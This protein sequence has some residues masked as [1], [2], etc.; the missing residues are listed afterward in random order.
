MFERAGPDICRAR[1]VDLPIL[2]PV[3]QKVKK[4]NKGWDR[5][6]SILFLVTCRADIWQ[7]TACAGLYNDCTSLWHLQKTW[8]ITYSCT[9]FMYL[10]NLCAPCDFTRPRVCPNFKSSY[11]HVHKIYIIGRQYG[12]IPRCRKSLYRPN[13][14]VVESQYLRTRRGFATL[15]QVLTQ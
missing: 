10:I 3:R 9:L 4:N 14:R 11:R 2:Q 15:C 13:A 1:S 8:L 5:Q 12:V 7:L 6:A